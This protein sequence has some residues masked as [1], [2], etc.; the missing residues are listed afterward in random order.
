[1]WSPPELSIDSSHHA[2]SPQEN[3]Q[4][5]DNAVYSGWKETPEILV[6]RVAQNLSPEPP[7]HPNIIVRHY[8][9][10]PWPHRL[11]P[12]VCG[13]YGSCA[14]QYASHTLKSNRRP[15]ASQISRGLP[16]PIPAAVRFL[17]R[18]GVM[19]APFLWI[20]RVGTK[21]LPSW[22]L[23]SN[24]FPAKVLPFRCSV[25]FQYSMP[26]F[27]VKARLYSQ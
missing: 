8:L 14:P 11:A 2:C 5:C 24:E 27:G 17:P 22:K 3:Y 6:T 18:K 23:L 15:R 10:I 9:M 16:L 19:L 4:S 1:M 26:F 12:V 20:A 13:G 7:P 25:P 21:G